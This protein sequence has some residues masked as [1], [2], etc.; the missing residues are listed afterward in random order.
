MRRIKRV[1][2]NVLIYRVIFLYI[3]I[4]IYIYRVIYWVSQKFC[5]ILVCASLQHVYQMTEAVSSI[6][7][8]S[9]LACCALL[10][11]VCDLKATQMNKQQRLIWELY[12][13]SSNWASTLSKQPKTF[14]VGKV[15]VQLFT[16]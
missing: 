8:V 7:V 1:I 10:H 12:F 2:N 5:N 15:M 3:Y 9:V 11:P 16:V 13:K 6:V 4:Y 14:A